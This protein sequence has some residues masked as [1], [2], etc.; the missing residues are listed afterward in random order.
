MDF[1]LNVLRCWE[2]SSAGN[3]PHKLGDLSSILRLVVLV[4]R[5][6]RQK[7]PWAHQAVRKSSQCVLGPK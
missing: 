1:E 5:E 6:Q 2:D 4:L 3:T 7:G